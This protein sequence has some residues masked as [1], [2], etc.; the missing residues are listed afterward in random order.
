MLQ[1]V[2]VNLISHQ[3]RHSNQLYG[4]FAFTLVLLSFLYLAAEL[5]MYGAEINVVK[6]RRLWPRSILQPPLTEADKRALRE[7]AGREQRRPDEHV[8]V[9][10]DPSETTTGSAAS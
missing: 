5:T 2:G 10:F 6:A 3:L 7:L 4:V 8:S 1:T 9:G